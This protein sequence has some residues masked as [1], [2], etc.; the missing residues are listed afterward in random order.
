[1]YYR[2]VFVIFVNLL[3][4]IFLRKLIYLVIK[5]FFGFIYD[6]R[7]EY[8]L[9]VLNDLLILY[10]YVYCL[11]LLLKKLFILGLMNKKKR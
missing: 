10:V 7:L 11:C 8:V 6:I 2:Y 3:V 5:I 9:N 1:M 4:L